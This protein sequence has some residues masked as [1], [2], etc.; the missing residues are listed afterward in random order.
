[1]NLAEPNSG[2][3]KSFAKS[4]ARRLL[5]RVDNPQKLRRLGEPIF[6]LAGFR[7]RE[8]RSQMPA[9]LAIIK[10]DRLGDVVLCSRLLAGLR[11]AWPQTR[12]TLFVRESLVDLARLCPDVDEVIGAPVDE[13]LMLF[14][15]K[16]GEYGCWQQQVAKWFRFCYHGGLWKKHFDAAIVPRWDTDYYGAIPL[17]Y[18][19]G[20][21]QRWGAI[22][23]ATPDK[24]IVNRGFDQLLT[25]VI[26]GQSIRHE[27]LLNESF[28]DAL[29]IQPVE[30]QKLVSWVK[31]S[32]RKKAADLMLA[33]GV[34]FSRKI[35]VVCLGAGLARKMWPVES[36]A[37]LCRTVFDFE[38]IQ[39]VTLGTAAEK[40]LGFQLKETLGSVVINLEGKLP[41]NLFPAAV[42]LGVLYIGSDTGTMH[43]AVTAGLPVLE[44]CCHPLDGEPDWPESPLRFGPWAVP[45]WVVQPEQATAPCKKHCAAS[46]AHCILGISIEKATGALRSLLEEIGMQSICMDVHGSKS[47]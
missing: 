16:T 33:A 38:M 22:E 5:R 26:A 36:Y 23:T 34:D 30:G 29:D 7:R 24:A 3:L 17:A 11:R 45:N 2:V 31:E 15:P 8:R 46:E 20:A 4:I 27:F 10:L 39:L 41:L 21:W 1:L 43:L 28:L 9:N 12:I 6:W 19:M 25:N 18:L 42:S 14:D 32:D 40:N 35:I 47:V 13:W 37:R 44:I